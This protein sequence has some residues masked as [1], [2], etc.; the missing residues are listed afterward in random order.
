MDLHFDADAHRYYLD[1]VRLP[2][3]T[4]VL[5]SAGLIDYSFLGDRRE[6]YLARGRAVH[7]ATH[8]DDLVDLDVEGLTSEILG[9]LKAWR[10]FRSD[11]GFTPLLIEERVCNPAF[12]YAGTLDR[13]GRLR[14]GTAIILDIKSG[15]APAAVRFQLAAYAACL[16]HPRTRLRRCV[17]LHADATYRVIPFQ[18][19]DYLHDFET[20]AAALRGWRHWEDL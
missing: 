2:G 10:A 20:F 4:S 11:F 16:P 17:E 5:E 8:A 13:V 12:G 7:A 15:I 18:T 9:Y 3:V 1:G 19:S 6:Q 14:D